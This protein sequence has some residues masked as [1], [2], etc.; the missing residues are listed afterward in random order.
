MSKNYH[1]NP[2]NAPLITK[3]GESSEYVGTRNVTGLLPEIF[4]TDVNKRFLDSTLE[5]LMSSGSLQAINHYIGEKTHVREK[6]DLYIEDGRT[7]DPYQ[8]VPGLVN[9]DNNGNVT[10]ALAYDD[11]LHNMNFSDVQLNQNSRVFDEE[12]YTLDLPINIDMFV[13]YH[14]YFWAVDVIP[15]IDVIAK[16][17]DPITID[18]IVGKFEYTTPELSNG[19]TLTFKNGMRVRFESIDV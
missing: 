8:F 19:K 4:R 12:G 11:L 18:D 5:Q 3:P 7:S 17:S 1:A 2:I 13:N 14:R 6:T 10:N 9:K 15:V 16:A